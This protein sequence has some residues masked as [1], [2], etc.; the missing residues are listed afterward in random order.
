MEAMRKPVKAL[1]L[2]TIGTILAVAIALM[3]FYGEHKRIAVA[4]LLPGW[5]IHRGVVAWTGDDGGASTFSDSFMSVPSGPPNPVGKP[6]RSCGQKIV[7]AH[8]G[9]ACGSCDAVFHMRCAAEGQCPVC[10]AAMGDPAK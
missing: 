1:V 8:D 4:L 6:C 5:I 9:G 3:A 10:S 2:M 7:F